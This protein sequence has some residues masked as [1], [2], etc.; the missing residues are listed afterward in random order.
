MNSICLLLIDEKSISEKIILKSFGQI[1]NSKIKKIYVIGDKNKFKK[2]YSKSIKYKKFIFIN[3]ENDLADNFLFLKK[4]T[5]EALK[6]FKSN[7]IKYLINMPINKKKFLKKNFAGYTEFFSFMCKDK[8]KENM[9]LY[10]NNFSVCPLTTHIELKKV[11]KFI[12]KKKIISTTKNISK[13]YKKINK[14]IKIIYLGLNPHAGI[15][16][17]KNSKEQKLIKPTIKLLQKKN[18]PIIGP[19]SADTAF[20]KTINK[21]FIGN[22]H[23]QVLIPF[24]LIN[25]FNGINITIGKKFIRMSPDHGTGKNL[26]SSDFVSNESFL[27]CIKFCEKY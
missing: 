23:D 6:L 13:F 20:R 21:V 25:N 9:L 18:Y 26:N 4:A 22:Y 24:K 3:I 7:K 12:T 17:G 15:D 10:N 1:L 19:V 14:K 8:K 27:E 11:D 16:L 5:N 2:I